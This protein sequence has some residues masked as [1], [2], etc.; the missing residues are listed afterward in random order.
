MKAIKKNWK[1]L[2]GVFFA[3]G[4]FGGGGLGPSLL[5]L[6]LGGGLIAWWYLDRKKAAEL[7]RQ[8]EEAQRAR[9]AKIRADQMLREAERKADA[10]KG[11]RIRALRP[12]EL[13]GQNLA[14]SYNVLLTDAEVAGM[15]Q[16]EGVPLDLVVDKD[17]VTVC[18]D[19]VIL[20]TT[21]ERADMVANFQ[22]R[23]LP[24]RGFVNPI[25]G[26]GWIYLAFYRSGYGL[27]EPTDLDEDDEE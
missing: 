20:G 12:L 3:L 15:R 17:V 14:Y 8:R 13:D 11:A 6:A 2:V 19:G 5:C 1:L 10:A 9:M 27:D 4:V 26:D 22:R 24:A 7:L 21:K 25:A 23:G 18:H 16:L